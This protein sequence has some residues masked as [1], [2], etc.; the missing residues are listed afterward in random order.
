MHLLYADETSLEPTKH[1]FFVYGGIAIPC[2]SAEFLH[3]EVE[4][5]RAEFKLPVA[6]L[7]KFNPRPEHLDHSDS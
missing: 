3:R 1:E 5:L 2:E 4:K 7:L 6:F